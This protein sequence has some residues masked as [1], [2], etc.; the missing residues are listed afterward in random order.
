MP[1]GGNWKQLFKG[2][3]NGDF[4]LVNFYLKMDMDPNYQHPEVLTTP[5]IESAHRGHLNIVKLLLENGADP[6]LKASLEGWTALEAAQQAEREE[7]IAFLSQ[8]LGLKYLPPTPGKNKL[9]ARKRKAVIISS[10]LNSLTFLMGAL[11]FMGA[12][13]WIFGSIQLITAIL[14][15]Y[16]G[17]QTKQEKEHVPLVFFILAFFNVLTALLIA[18]DYY[19]AGSDYIHFV[20]IFVAIV[21]TIAFL[22]QE[23]K[24]RNKN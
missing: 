3:E 19:R 21:S 5:L 11:T 12:G 14:N 16:V 23:Q 9:Q 7:V 22:I 8:H 17:F 4:E 20:W 18:L 10:F 2:A 24:H 6:H 13:K 1:T 15:G